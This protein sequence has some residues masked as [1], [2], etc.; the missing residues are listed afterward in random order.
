MRCG[1]MRAHAAP[2]SRARTP[3]CWLAASSL[4]FLNSSICCLQRQC[5]SPCEDTAGSRARRCSTMQPAP[6]PPSL[7]LVLLLPLLPLLPLVCS[8]LSSAI[9]PIFW[10]AGLQVPVH[11]HGPISLGHAGASGGYATPRATLVLVW[12]GLPRRTAHRQTSKADGDQ[13]R[14]G[15][16]Q[17]RLDRAVRSDFFNKWRKKLK[18]E[19]GR[20]SPTLGGT[21][22]GRGRFLP[23]WGARV[24]ANSCRCPPTTLARRFSPHF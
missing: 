3:T 17:Q 19:R 1:R 9:G 10:L 20:L 16:I 23:G 13:N 21:L 15:G 6:C 12:W 5:F 2:P 14:A 18:D 4:A 8:V 7:L 11:G 24:L 22:G